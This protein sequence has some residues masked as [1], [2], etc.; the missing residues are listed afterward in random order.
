[1]WHYFATNPYI[2]VSYNEY[3][4]FLYEWYEECQYNI[5]LVNCTYYYYCF[6][7]FIYCSVAVWQLI[8]KHDDDDDD[9]DDECI[10]KIKTL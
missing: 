1:M 10:W 8:N 9:D 2:V 6:L 5:I 3:K 4:V 7:L